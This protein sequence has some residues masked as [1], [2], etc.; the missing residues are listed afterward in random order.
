MGLDAPAARATAVVAHVENDLD[1]SEKDCHRNRTK[2]PSCTKA[3]VVERYIDGILTFSPHLPS[4]A[5]T[6]AGGD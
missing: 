1:S 5:G 2:G 4:S 3:W 6:Q